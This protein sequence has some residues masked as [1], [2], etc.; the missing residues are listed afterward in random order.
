VVVRHI[1]LACRA[2]AGLGIAAD[3]YGLGWEGR[4]L[5]AGVAAVAG[6]VPLAYA[7]LSG[8][9][10]LLFIWDFLTEWLAPAAPGP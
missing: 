4:M 2:R 1:D 10:W 3:L 7:V 9:L 5:L 8:Y 6:I